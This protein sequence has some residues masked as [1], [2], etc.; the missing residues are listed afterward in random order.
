MKDGALASGTNTWRLAGGTGKMKGIKG[1]GG[2]KLTPGE[3][4]GLN[5]DCTGEYTLAAAKP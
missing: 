4:G 3:G 1:T 2:C 5:Y